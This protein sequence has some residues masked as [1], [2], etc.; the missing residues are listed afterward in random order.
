[1]VGEAFLTIPSTELRITGLEKFCKLGVLCDGAVPPAV[2]GLVGGCCDCCP[3]CGAYGTRWLPVSWLDSVDSV[4]SEEASLR[5]EMDE[6]E[7]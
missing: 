5:C 6:C 3:D 1:M 2:E 7:R 4:D